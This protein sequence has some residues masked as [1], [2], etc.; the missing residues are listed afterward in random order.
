MW[1][2]FLE[3]QHCDNVCAVCTADVGVCQG[4]TNINIPAKDKPAGRI[5]SCLCDC[6]STVSDFSPHSHIRTKLQFARAELSNQTSVWLWAEL[7][8]LLLV[9]FYSS[10]QALSRKK[11][12]YGFVSDHWW[13]LSFPFQELLF[14]CSAVDLSAAPSLSVSVSTSAQ[15]LTVPHVTNIKLISPSCFTDKETQWVNFLCV[16]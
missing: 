6:A 12:C 5:H 3:H 14:T 16:N 10:S 13:K 15:W 2:A 1:G 8:R 7:S 4:Q 11:T 9:A